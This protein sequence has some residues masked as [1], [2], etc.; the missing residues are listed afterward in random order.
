M[1]YK[2]DKINEY[3]KLT[4]NSID[5]LEQVIPVLKSYEGKVINKRLPNLISKETGLFCYL[6]NNYSL[7]N[8][9][10]W[11]TTSNEK[12]QIFLGYKG[13]DTRFS[14]ELFNRGSRSLDTIKMD[15]KGYKQALSKIDEWKEKIDAIKSLKDELESDANLYGVRYII[16]EGV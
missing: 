9:E 10:I 13:Q 2:I 4:Q 15:L 8:L 3:I 16:M 6:N 7:Q 14:M 12:I 11:K 5:I 1:Q